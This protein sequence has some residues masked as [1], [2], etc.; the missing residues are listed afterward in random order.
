[1]ALVTGWCSSRLLQLVGP[2]F[3]GSKW[4]LLLLCALSAIANIVILS[5]IGTV[6][7]TKGTALFIQLGILLGG[8]ACFAFCQLRVA[9]IAKASIEAALA[10]LRVDLMKQ[11][12]A[13]DLAV[14]ENLGRPLL[15]K[16]LVGDI[17]LISNA[18]L[19]MINAVQAALQLVGAVA[20]L[21][22][23]SKIVFAFG[24]G[25]VFLAALAYQK[26]AGRAS[27]L[28]MKAAQLQHA[29]L[30]ILEDAL[31]G[32][33]QLKQSSRRSTALGDCAETAGQ[34]AA[35]AG[36]AAREAIGQTVVFGQLMMYLLL[37]IMVWVLPGL[38]FGGA[39]VGRATMV[40]LFAL[41]ALANLLNGV[42]M[43]TFADFAAGSVLNLES[44]LA[45]LSAGIVPKVD[46]Q[47]VPFERLSFN[48]VTYQHMASEGEP[49]AMIGPLNFE[50]NKSEIVFIS[51]GNGAG[52]TTL[53][54][55]L[56]GLYSSA[57]GVLCL[58]DVP[59]RAD[60][61]VFQRLLAVVFSDFHLPHRLWG[62]TEK[63][64]D[65]V[66]ELLIMFELDTKVNAA[67]GAFT[68]RE[69]STGQRKRLA[70][71]TSLL[72]QKPVLVLDEFAADQDPVFRRRFYREI[73]P[74]LRNQGMTIL[75][76]SH[77]EDY[78]DVADRRLV[79]EEG[80]FRQQ[81]AADVAAGR[82]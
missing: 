15:L 22:L 69:L 24:V 61:P 14:F 27:G 2:R 26:R 77:D 11:I 57:S 75:A 6:G 28:F 59:I 18:T 31:R 55:L 50:L 36:R 79:M 72:E 45:M 80:R 41:G 7:E 60:D 56:V 67:E 5:G 20:Y 40:L 48:G 81:S 73:L 29:T 34:L 8:I 21:F 46:L 9:H 82:A 65:L 38:G 16:V 1:M 58:N 42:T 23:V 53:I 33:M 47:E 66:D 37:Y 30:G 35:E 71:I 74:T 19:P 13:T 54:K 3:R 10:E 70:L 62:I 49:G 25:G 63:D 12:V 52:K 78:F 32:F 17:E 4:R 43:F 68:T 51:G 76:I 64:R 39:T 44:R